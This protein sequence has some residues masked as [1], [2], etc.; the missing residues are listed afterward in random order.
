M[1]KSIAHNRMLKDIENPSILLLSNSLGIQ[2]DDE[3]FFD[4][5]MQIKSDDNFIGIILKK[6]E[7][8]KPNIIFL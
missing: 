8:I 5:D 7:L 2:K 4:I 3:E 6:I 1:K